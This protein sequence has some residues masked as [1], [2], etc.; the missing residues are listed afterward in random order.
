MSDLILAAITVLASFILPKNETPATTFD[1]MKAVVAKWEK[2]E[3]DEEELAYHRQNP[4]TSV[5]PRKARVLHELKCAG[6][7]LGAFQANLGIE[8]A[9][10]WLRFSG[11]LQ[12]APAG[13]DRVVSRGID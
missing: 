3:I 2:E 11:A 10:G 13:E 12:P 5:H 8:L 4:E 1:R 7:K 6:I 9:L